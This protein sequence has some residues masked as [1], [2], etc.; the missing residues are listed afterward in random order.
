VSPAPNPRTLRSWRQ[1]VPHSKRSQEP[2]PS[3]ASPSHLAEATHD[4]VNADRVE[5]VVARRISW[6]RYRIERETG[7]ADAAVSQL[8]GDN[9]GEGNVNGPANRLPRTVVISLGSYESGRPPSATSPTVNTGTRPSVDPG[10][11][12]TIDL[13]KAPSVV[14]PSVDPGESGTWEPPS[15]HIS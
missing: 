9:E 2:C 1:Q 7:A 11:T 4:A 10:W 8:S 6:G 12:T 5:R 15:V 3:R 14:A 13:G